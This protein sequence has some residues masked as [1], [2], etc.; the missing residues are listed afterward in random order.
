MNHVDFLAYKLHA[1]QTVFLILQMAKDSSTYFVAK[2][3]GQI[4]GSLGKKDYSLYLAF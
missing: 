3:Q 1:H 4:T 2:I